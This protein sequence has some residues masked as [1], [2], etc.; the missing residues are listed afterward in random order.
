MKKTTIFKIIG[1]ILLVVVIVLIVLGL[2]LS[3]PRTH[4]GSL[5]LK[6]G[7]IFA[8][9]IVG[10]PTLVLLMWGFAPQMTKLG[11]QMQSEVIEHAKEDIKEATSK[12]ADVI[13]PSVAP[14]IKKGVEIVK[15]DKEAELNEAKELL[16]KNLITKEEYEKMR[17]NILGIK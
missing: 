15:K 2:N 6:P 1:F 8:A 12:T 7:Y 5:D 4:F 16:N 14:A 9:F 17:K 10:F 3:G 11:S 13:I